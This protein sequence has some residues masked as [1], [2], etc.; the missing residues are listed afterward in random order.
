MKVVSS[1]EHIVD[2]SDF[3]FS[4]MP[5]DQAF[6]FAESFA[7]AIKLGKDSPVFVDCNAISPETTLS[8]NKLIS[9][10]GGKMIKVGI[11]GP[12]PGTSTSTKFYASGENASLIDF[13]AGGD[14]QFLN[15]GSNLVHASAIKM[16][17]A[18]LTKGVMVLQSSALIA[19]ELLGV[20]EAFH[21]E[22]KVSQN[23]H[24]KLI[25]KRVSS[26]ACDATRW[27]GE[28][29]QIS[30]MYRIL[31]LTP[32]LHKGAG[33]IFR[34]LEMSPLSLETRETYDRNRSL[35]ETLNIYKNSIK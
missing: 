14:I 27:A 31:G 28:M 21:A 5:P 24:W 17:Y 26:L 1:M 34:L 35:Q 32:N 16:C 23:F 19:A 3:V 6:E 11:I 10:A 9:S 30:E 15:L 33:D 4:I 7:T 12:P 22:L 20:G 2:N 8:L 13:I 18:A 25:E 29:D